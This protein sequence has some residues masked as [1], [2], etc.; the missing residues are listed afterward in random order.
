MPEERSFQQAPASQSLRTLLSDDQWR[1][2]QQAAASSFLDR[3]AKLGQDG[4]NAFEAWVLSNQHKEPA[5]GTFDRYSRHLPA[6]VN[7]AVT[8][9]GAAVPALVPT[10]V[11]ALLFPGLTLPA[12][13]V[14]AIAVSTG[15]KL[16]GDQSEAA[17]A[18]ALQRGD[19]PAAA[20]EISREIERQGRALDP[21][22][23]GMLF[24]ENGLGQTV[25]R[26][27]AKALLKLGKGVCGGLG[28]RV[29]LDPA[30]PEDLGKK[31]SRYFRPN[32]ELYFCE[33]PVGR[34]SDEAYDL[35]RDVLTN[36]F[37]AIA[38]RGGRGY[39]DTEIE[40]RDLAGQ[41]TLAT[42]W[43]V[44]ERSLFETPPRGIIP[45][46]AR[47][48]EGYSTRYPRPSDVRGHAVGWNVSLPGYAL[49]VWLP[50]DERDPGNPDIR[51]TMG[52]VSN[53]GLIEY[54]KRLVEQ[55]W[56][57]REGLAP[58]IYARYPRKD[59]A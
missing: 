9:A 30:K 24:G 40:S 1:D 54:L 44:F 8:L 39:G 52:L 25:G 10:L 57:K 12:S 13:I 33:A 7:W 34:I 14:L 29:A 27:L 42:Y 4:G 46:P 28:Y 41:A 49:A 15:V 3:V 6:G 5:Q 58:T 37:A 55:T 53:D 36:A 32:P 19:G 22:V 50:L 59:G 16:L 56:A 18:H 17:I 35:C 31:V 38:G 11:P 20:L 51:S 43:T 21:V 45:S 26:R 23:R 2:L 47:R 48:K